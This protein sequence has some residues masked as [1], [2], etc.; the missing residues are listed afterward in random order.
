MELFKL[1]NVSK[2]FRMDGQEVHALQDVTLSLDAGDIT[3]VLGPSGSGKSTLLTLLGGLSSPSRG[4][5]STADVPCTKCQAPNWRS[6]ATGPL[7]SSFNR[8]I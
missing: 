5:S 7:G 3:V 6:S 4:A 2:T 1:H 8:T